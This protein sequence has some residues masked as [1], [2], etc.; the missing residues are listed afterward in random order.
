[1]E[2]RKGI[3]L[4][5]LVVM[6]M[7]CSIP[8]Y[9]GVDKEIYGD[10]TLVPLAWQAIEEEQPEEEI[11]A[12][13]NTAEDLYD[14]FN[15]DN[16]DVTY[17]IVIKTENDS[18]TGL[19]RD[20][21]QELLAA[22]GF[23]YPNDLRIKMNVL[24]YRAKKTDA[25]S[26]GL[27]YT[28]LVSGFISDHWLDLLPERF[29]F[30][31]LLEEE[32]VGQRIQ[33][34]DNVLIIGDFT[35]AELIRLQNWKKN[36]QHWC[37]IINGESRSAAQSEIVTIFPLQVRNVI[38]ASKEIFCTFET[39]RF[40]QKIF[41]EKSSDPD[42]SLQV[43]D[44][45]LYCHVIITGNKGNIGYSQEKVAEFPDASLYRIKTKNLL[46]SIALQ[47]DNN[48]TEKMLLISEFINPY[49]VTFDLQKNNSVYSIKE[50]PIITATVEKK[51]DDIFQGIDINMDEWKASLYLVDENGEDQSLEITQDALQYA[52]ELNFETFK[53]GK[54]HYRFKVWNENNSDYYWEKDY[55][56]QIKNEPPK[57]IKK[58][59]NK[60]VSYYLSVPVQLNSNPETSFDLAPLFYD[61][62]GIEQ[63]SYYIEPMEV[64]GI[65]IIGDKLNI[66]P[67]QLQ[68]GMTEVTVYAKDQFDQPSEDGYRIAFSVMR[69]AEYLNSNDQGLDLSSDKEGTKDKPLTV[70]VTYHFPET[71]NA[72][73]MQLKKDGKLMELREKLRAEG[74]VSSNLGNEEITKQLTFELQED[75]DDLFQVCFKAEMEKVDLD[76]GE[77]MLHVS[78]SM[79]GDA[80]K[81]A[82]K[83]AD[84]QYTIINQPPA[85]KQ[86]V[87]QVQNIQFEIPGPWILQKNYCDNEKQYRL[88]ELIDT[89]PL[90]I[91]TIN[92]SGKSMQ[93]TAKEGH[94]YIISDQDSKTIDNNTITWDTAQ[95]DNIPTLVFK[96]TKRGETEVHLEITDQ[97][98]ASASPLTFL[99]TTRYH[100]EARLN[101]IGVITVSL[102]IL[103]VL[104]AIILYL[105]KPSFSQN[106][107]VTVSLGTYQQELS[108][109]KWRKK[110]VSIEDIL[111]YC[112]IPMWK[113]FL[114]DNVKK[115]VLKPG[116][117]KSAAVILNA[118]KY[119]IQVKVNHALLNNNRIF[120]KQ[121]DTVEL[122]IYADT[123]VDPEPSEPITLRL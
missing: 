59:E 112:G 25:F 106:S 15:S 120:L 107:K 101:T 87:S 82:Q 23:L 41:M 104:M 47:L 5:A 110:Q 109:E 43:S 61:D 90:D 76:T 63:L 1:M 85:L 81:E 37:R 73:L 100:D 72:Y 53:T 88:D 14:G 16:A 35:E 69:V 122:Y 26:R 97:D 40:P 123:S 102:I 121:G 50:K 54:Y 7:Y 52:S 83:E 46:D 13:D 11:T 96:A 48:G 86:E 64:Q 34:A 91:I 117:K 75:D 118:C 24:T 98:N 32:N 78:V 119:D 6:L 20:T 67:E 114:N 111:I 116:G 84:E 8:A 62:S 79:D 39:G 49:N 29:V 55:F 42:Y 44:G 22:I 93:L 30:D 115:I 80:F 99:F 74:T 95:D 18:F 77:C 17:C 105:I 65:Q 57:L 71:V 51:Q 103:L 89:E 45:G 4:I 66:N 113:D 108:L 68:E 28:S 92:I 94:S 58:N 9:A 38:E 70:F 60:Q 2:K 33:E 56:L 3:L 10:E 19:S 12:V 21:V 31:S 36:S 27:V